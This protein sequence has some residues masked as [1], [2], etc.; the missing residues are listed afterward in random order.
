MKGNACVRGHN[1]W[2]LKDGRHYCL[3]C[4]RERE[5]LKNRGGS[6]ARPTVF[7][8]F[9]HKVNK[10]ASCWLWMGAT[11]TRGFPR[12][13]DGKNVIGAHRF[14]WRHFHG[15]IH[16]GNEILQLCG[17]RGCVNPAHLEKLTAKQ[18]AKK[19]AEEK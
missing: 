15:R 1:D 14:S 3:E 13:Y 4:R 6:Y 12:F 9:I 17:V 2:Q 16:K 5:V 11:D 7:Q 10:T 8:R 18:R 19:Y